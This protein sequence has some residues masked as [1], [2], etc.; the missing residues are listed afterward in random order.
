MREH[1]RKT[2]WLGAIV[3]A[4]TLWASTAPSAAAATAPL[5]TYSAHIEAY[6][7]KNAGTYGAFAGTVGQAKQMEAIRVSL[8]PGSYAGSIRYQAHIEGRG[9]LPTANT[10]YSAGQDGG[11]VGLGLQLEAVKLELTGAIKDS[12]DIYYSVHCAS[13]GWLAWAKNGAPAGTQGYANQAEAIYIQLIK[14]GDPAPAPLSSARPYAFASSDTPKVTYEVHG[15]GYGWQG[16]RTNS[17]TAGTTGL[18]KQIEAIRLSVASSG[19]AGSIQ[20]SA[21]VEGIGWQSDVTN[22]ATAGTTGRA[23]RLEAVRIRLT[24]SLANEFDVYYRAHVEAGGW[25][26]WAKNGTAAG[27][28]GAGKQM[29]A[30]QVTLVPKALQGPTLGR[31]YWT[32]SDFNPPLN[33][34]ERAIFDEASSLGVGVLGYNTDATCG[35]WRAYQSH[36]Y[37]GCRLYTGGIY[38]HAPLMSNSTMARGVTKHEVAHEIIARTCGTTSPPISIVSGVDR[39]EQ[40]TD[41]YAKAYFGMASTY[42]YNSPSS[43]DTAIAAQ[44]RVGNCG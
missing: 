25:L 44:I 20:Y 22:N 10:W 27:S 37:Y 11:T 35:N 16:V 43:T 4:A 5:I 24:G 40:V 7:W 3:L 2:T 30:I 8:N 23:L 26:G 19:L 32:A 42:A 9:W 21:H 33:A 1:L 31:S 14:K 41:A 12:Y 36:P 34:I 38:V 18:A 15:E 29:E 39:S 17:Q 6:G 13:L 28:I